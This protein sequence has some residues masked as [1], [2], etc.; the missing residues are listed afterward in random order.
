M[1]KVTISRRRARLASEPSTTTSTNDRS[2]QDPTTDEPLSLKQHTEPVGD[3]TT[4]EPVS[5]ASV[6]EA[7]SDFDLQPLDEGLLEDLA[8]ATCLKARRKNDAKPPSVDSLVAMP[9]PGSSHARLL[10]EDGSSSVFPA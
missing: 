7:I 3:A 8:L 4:D 2:T 1:A 5:S 10:A 9:G 6:D